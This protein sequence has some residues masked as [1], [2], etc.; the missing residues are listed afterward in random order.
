MESQPG[1]VR[2]FGIYYQAIEM[3]NTIFL[4]VV[5][6]IPSL[7]VGQNSKYQ[8]LLEEEADPYADVNASKTDKFGGILVDPKDPYSMLDDVTI[9]YE[10]YR[11]EGGFVPEPYEEQFDMMKYLPI[12]ILIIIFVVGFILL[13]KFVSSVRNFATPMK[14]LILVGLNLTLAFGIYEAQGWSKD[15]TPALFWTSISTIFTYGYLFGFKKKS[16][17]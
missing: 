9:D 1:L 8:I 6:L 2:S 7:G 13:R 3:K 14:W 15:L 10:K 4:F 5:L 12:A 16:K 11:K 17:E